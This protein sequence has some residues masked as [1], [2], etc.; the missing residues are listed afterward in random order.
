VWV[1]GEIT[2][3]Q[4]LKLAGV[5][6]TGGHAKQLIGDGAVTV[7]GRKELRRGRK[8]VATD[9]VRVG[10]VTLVVEQRSVEAGGQPPSPR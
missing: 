7:N 9:V 6:E 4:L 10:A 5:A 3:G 2:L 8:L 1:R